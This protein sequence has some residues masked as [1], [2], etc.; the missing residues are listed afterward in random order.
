LRGWRRATLLG[1]AQQPGWL[2]GKEH[3]VLGEKPIDDN[4]ASDYRWRL[5][6]H[7]LPF[8]ANYWLDEITREPCLAFEAHT[9]QEPTEIR[10][11]ICAPATI[12]PVCHPSQP[13]SPR[14]HGNPRLSTRF[15]A[16][17]PEMERDLRRSPKRRKPACAGLPHEWS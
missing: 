15:Q 12:A 2:R 14:I 17:V 11:A 3:G 10:A 5:D 7:L 4:T 13:E 16:P 9:L 6:R 8:F 1:A